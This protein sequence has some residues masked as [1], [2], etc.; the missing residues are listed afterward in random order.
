MAH[1]K[2]MRDPSHKAALVEV[3]PVYQEL[4]GLH[5]MPCP[6]GCGAVYDGE[7]TGT[8]RHFDAHVKKRNCKRSESSGP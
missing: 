5:V 7:R 2:L 8:S 1:L 4:R 3:S 6:F